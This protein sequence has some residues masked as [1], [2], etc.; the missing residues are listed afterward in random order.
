[1]IIGVIAVALFAQ[2]KVQPDNYKKISL[3][4]SG[5]VAP[6]MP[7]YSFFEHDLKE[8]TLAGVAAFVGFANIPFVPN[9][10]AEPYVIYSYTKG[11]SPVLLVLLV[12]G[13]GTIS[14]SISYILGRLFG[15]KFIKKLTKKEFKHSPIIDRLSGPITFVTHALPIPIPGIFPFLFGA[16]K[17][18]YR[19]FIL[20]AFLGV[21]VRYSLILY[22]F[23]KYGQNITHLPVLLKSIF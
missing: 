23:V 4:V 21:T 6:K 13:I 9:P 15:P 8:G 17:S 22:L 12:A 1:M 7:F 19:S 11:T 14:S 20:A 16:Y 5:E 18:S 10:P 3:F 2:S